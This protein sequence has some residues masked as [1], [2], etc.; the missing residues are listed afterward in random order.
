M[1]TANEQFKHLFKTFKKESGEFGDKMNDADGAGKAQLMLQLASTLEGALGSKNQMFQQLQLQTQNLVESAEK[2]SSGDKTSIGDFLKWAGHDVQ[3]REEGGLVGPSFASG[4]K[5]KWLNGPDT[6]YA[7]EHNGQ[8]MVAHG[9]EGLFTKS[10]SKDGFI[11]PFDN[12][13]TR[14]NPMLTMTRLAQ[15]KRLGFTNAPPGF[16]RGGF[17]LFNP[18]SWFGDKKAQTFMRGAHGDRNVQIQGNSLAAQVGRNRQNLNAIMAEMG[19]ALGGPLGVQNLKDNKTYR[20]SQDK[21]YFEQS[22][23]KSGGGGNFRLFKVSLILRYSICLIIL[24]IL[25]SKWTTKSISHLCH[26]S[27]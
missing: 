25:H 8:P 11:V 9:G 12:A 5:A 21:G 1:Y 23:I 13:A 18:M 17:N 2:V 26:N 14:N 24:K 19:Y 27:I 16:E 3:S 4:G 15:A 22:K 7:A 20:I 10:G 6:G